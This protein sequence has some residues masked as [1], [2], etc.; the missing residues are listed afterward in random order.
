MPAWITSLLREET[1]LPMPPVASATLTSWPA[2][3][4]ARAI[5][6][7]T[8]PA[9]MTRTCME[10]H[11]E[12]CG[13]RRYGLTGQTGLEINIMSAKW[14]MQEAKA[15]LGELVRKAGSEG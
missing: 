14:Q 4:A 15:R 8:T 5:A 10:G 9:P 3:A 13:I 7:P 6:R 2:S 11:L 12:P 1:P